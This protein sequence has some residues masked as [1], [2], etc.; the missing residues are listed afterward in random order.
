MNNDVWET[1][2]LTREETVE[3]KV[4]VKCRVPI[5]TAYSTRNPS[6]TFKS[7]DRLDGWDKA[8]SEEMYRYSQNPVEI[9]N[10]ILLK[11]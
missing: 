7:L 10:S 8:A 1:Y 9:N 3:K 2:S 6:T 4:I 5:Q 11:R